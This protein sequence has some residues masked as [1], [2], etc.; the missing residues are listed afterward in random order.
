MKLTRMIS[1]V[2]SHTEG[3]PTRTILGGI[4]PLPGKT[5][6]EKILSRKS[7]TDARAGQIVLAEPDFL[8]AHDA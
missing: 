1:T 4:P 2:D 3:E 8:F 5:I 7:G 6:A